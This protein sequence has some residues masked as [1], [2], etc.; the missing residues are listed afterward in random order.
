MF[1][2]LLTELSTISLYKNVFEDEAVKNLVTLLELLCRPEPGPESMLKAYCGVYSG[3]LCSMEYPNLYEHISSLLLYDENPFTL[4]CERKETNKAY[5]L[6]TQAEREYSIFEKLAKVPYSLLKEALKQK[7]DKSHGFERI[8]GELPDWNSE[9]LGEQE[10]SIS[11][12]L[13]KRI[14]EYENNGAGIFLKHSFFFWDGG[15]KQIIPV[16]N[17]DPVTLD[18][19]YL[20]ESQKETALKNTRM[21]LDGLPANNILLYGDRGTG[22]SSMVKAI[23]NHYSH[24]GLRL[25]EI[26]S[27]H[28]EQIPDVTSR[29]YDRGLKFILFIDDLAFENNEEKYTALKGVLEG[30]IEHKPDNILLYA[31]SNRRH[32]IKETFADRKG[33]S[34]GDPDEEV[35][36][37][38]NIQE[39]LSLS[40]R[41]GITVVFTS[42]IRKDYLMIVRKMAEEE[43]ID[44]DPA[45]LEQKAM[46]WEMAYNGMTPRTARQFINWL[47]GECHYLRA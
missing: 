5:S 34:S 47:K 10:K 45:L 15:T 26:P 6:R 22:K 40:D 16:K 44:I 29:L 24:M 1:K 46:Q 20:V 33:L 43:D 2:L 21:F 12:K 9:P 38:D 37:R 32:L 23:V 30:G 11:I 13:S 25:I 42:P 39:K 36:A 28:L 14:N 3:L 18:K 7:C 4:A 41:F 35:R 31:T 17:P 27:K 8:L 19:L